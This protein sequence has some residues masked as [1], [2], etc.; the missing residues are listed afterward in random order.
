MIKKIIIKIVTISCT[1]RSGT[2]KASLAQRYLYNNFNEEVSSSYRI[3]VES[4][5]G[6]VLIDGLNIFLNILLTATQERFL[7]IIQNL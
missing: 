7:T 3:G 1:S 2:G 4:F 5:K 6:S